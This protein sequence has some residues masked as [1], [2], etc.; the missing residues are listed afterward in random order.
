MTQ[1]DKLHKIAET[2]GLVTQLLHL[3]EECA[4]L[5]QAAHK[6]VRF[7]DDRNKLMNLFEELE[8]VQIMMDQIRYLLPESKTVTPWIREF[9]INREAERMTRNESR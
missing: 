5:I 7:P 6:V 8:D 1:T 4:E 3:S 2:H 9:K